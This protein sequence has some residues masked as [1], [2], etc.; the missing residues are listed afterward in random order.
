[1]GAAI[2]LGFVAG[3][4][5]YATILA[6]GL[7][8]RFGWLYLGAVGQPLQVLAEPAVLIAAGV[9]YLAEFFADKVPWVDSLWDAFHTCIR[10][11][12]AVILA[13]AALGRFDPVLRLTLVILCGGVAFASHSSKAAARLVVNHSPEP[14]T[15]IGMSLAEDAFAPFGI[16]LSLSHPV[17]VL[18]LVLTFLGGFVWLMPKI[19]RA[20]RRQFVALRMRLL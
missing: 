17:A 13:A 20:I 5:L 15:N 18:L 10:P 4:R 6:L 16:W 11:L 3:I 8:I 19:F 2:G 1:I 9:A 7:A 12:G 14:F